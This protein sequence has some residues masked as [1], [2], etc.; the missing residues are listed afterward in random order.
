MVVCE[1]WHGKNGVAGGV[2]NGSARVEKVVKM[3]SK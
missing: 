3:V 1:K 2:G